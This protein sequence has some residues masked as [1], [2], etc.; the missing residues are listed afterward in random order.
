MRCAQRP[1]C[2][3]RRLSLRRQTASRR[4]LR[5]SIRNVVG[6]PSG[7]TTLMRFLHLVSAPWALNRVVPGLRRRALWHRCS[8][9]S[10]MERPRPSLRAHGVSVGARLQVVIR[11]SQSIIRTPLN[12][13]NLLRY[14]ELQDYCESR[15]SASQTGSWR[16]LRQAIYYITTVS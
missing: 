13:V 3:P 15:T 2:S 12:T 14:K 11:P 16:S 8:G 4:P 5:V 10:P 1:A 9:D 6:P 7:T